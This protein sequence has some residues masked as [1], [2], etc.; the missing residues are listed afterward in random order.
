MKLKSKAIAFI[1]LVI[2]ALSSC[3]SN[4]RLLSNQEDIDSLMKEVTSKFGD[5]DIT[6]VSIIGEGDISEKIEWVHVYYRKDG[7]YY[8]QSF[9]NGEFLEPAEAGAQSA[10]DARYKNMPSEKM[11]TFTFENVVSTYEKAIPEIKEEFKADNLTV[12][13]TT[14]HDLNRNVSNENGYTIDITVCVTIKGEKNTYYVAKIR[15]DSKGNYTID[16]D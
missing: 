3:T 16:Y 1:A 11:G 4:D 5:E 2:L 10:L 14:L 13:N 8:Q 7:V 15:L 6:S 12:S 9:N